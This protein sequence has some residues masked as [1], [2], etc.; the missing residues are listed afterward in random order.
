MI[1]PPDSNSGGLNTLISSPFK[2]GSYGGQNKKGEDQSFTGIT[3]NPN[4]VTHISNDEDV[5]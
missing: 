4:N 5:S 3:S 2:N 1:N